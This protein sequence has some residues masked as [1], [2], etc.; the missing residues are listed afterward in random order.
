MNKEIIIF[1]NVFHFILTVQQLIALF[2][3]DIN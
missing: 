1:R 2:N 3:V